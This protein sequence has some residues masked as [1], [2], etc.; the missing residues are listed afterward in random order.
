MGSDDI[1]D[2]YELDAELKRV[3]AVASTAEAHG[4]MAG[5]LCGGLKLDGL[6]WLRQFLIGVGVK[7]EPAEDQRQWFYE[8]HRLSSEQLQSIEMDFV[9][10]LPDDSEPVPARLDAIG[11]WASGFLA[12]FGTSGNDF[13]DSKIPPD[14]QSALRDL[15]EIS[16]IDIDVDD[17]LENDDEIALFELTE[18][19][20]LV[21]LLA[22]TEWGVS[23]QG[24]HTMPQDSSQQDGSA[25]QDSMQ[26]NTQGGADA[27]HT[28]H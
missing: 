19:L 11:D 15:T 1:L 6:M 24:L 26:S 27:D 21:A 3:D 10:L 12:G 13:T 28:V 9:P 14:L 8:F 16:K 22:Y 18:Y 20:K 5:Q 4:I 25:Q 7:R 23:R 17:E 2:Y